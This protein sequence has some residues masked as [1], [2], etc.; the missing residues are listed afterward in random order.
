MAQAG[1][2]VAEYA[3]GTDNIPSHGKPDDNGLEFATMYLPKPTLK[4]AL[5]AGGWFGFA[6]HKAF[7]QASKDWKYMFSQPEAE[8]PTEPYGPSVKEPLY[9]QPAPQPVRRASK[10]TL[11]TRVARKS[12]LV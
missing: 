12:L 7:Q 5:N 3:V 11:L 6:P 8:G 9:G 1:G 10:D 4:G 2:I